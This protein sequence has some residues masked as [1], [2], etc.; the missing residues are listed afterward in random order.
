MI[1]QQAK[2]PSKPHSVQLADLSWPEAEQAL[3]QLPLVLLPIGAA[4]K[5]H[6]HH[7]P[8]N[9][10]WL[11]AEYLATAVMQQRPLLRLPTLGYGH[12]PAFLDYPGSV[13]LAANAFRDTVIDI[14]SS[15]AAQGARRF[16]LLNTGISTVPP[17]QA[18]REHLASK[19]IRM[20]F[21]DT[22]TLMADIEQQLG[23]QPRGSHADELETSVMLYIAPDKVNMTAAVPELA[24]PAGPGRFCRRA[25]EGCSV[26]SPSGSWGDPTLANADKG[27]RYI[28][29]L[30]TRL[31]AE[32]DALLES[33]AH[34]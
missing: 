18:A 23:S 22:S 7:L 9:T 26:I 8:L 25:G 20:A 6:G 24:R 13:S 27:R 33:V 5:Q 1:I 15:L 19:G 16:Y 34:S 32:I 10:D 21:T 31:C 28:E 4:T 11:Q 29:A 17:L 12:Y 2:A 30:L 3:R 14:C